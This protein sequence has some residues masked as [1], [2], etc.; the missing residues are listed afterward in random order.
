VNKC[1]RCNCCGERNTFGTP[2]YLTS[3]HTNGRT[4]SE[5]Y[6]RPCFDKLRELAKDK[7][8]GLDKFVDADAVTHNMG[9]MIGMVKDDKPHNRK[10]IAINVSEAVVVDG[11]VFAQ[12]CEKANATA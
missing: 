3:L 6:C 4:A 1:S 2:I 9:V 7:V 10:P 11:S 12:F 8:P 5:W